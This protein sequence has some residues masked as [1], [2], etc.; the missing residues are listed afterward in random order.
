MLLKLLKRIKDILK[1]KDIKTVSE[2][3][4][5][6]RNKVLKRIEDVNLLFNEMKLCI[7]FERFSEL[8]DDFDDHTL[9]LFI[10][11]KTSKLD[12]CLTGNIDIVEKFFKNIS[13]EEIN[14][15]TSFSETLI[16]ELIYYLSLE[17]NL[18][19]Y[20]KKRKV[21]GYLIKRGANINEGGYM[22]SSPLLIAYK[23][24]S[25]QTVKFLVE[26]GANV[27]QVVGSFKNNIGTEVIDRRDYDLLNYLMSKGLDVEIKV[28][29]YDSLIDYYE[30]RKIKDKFER[31]IGLNILKGKNL[32]AKRN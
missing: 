6:E 23:Y 17:E 29:G 15:K 1:I 8:Y 25:I 4:Y 26:R 27:N 16:S 21:V 32:K 7:T 9:N 20:E 18:K 30:K 10:K 31:K 3:D 5:Y 2:E 24:N 22:D 12:I 28:F 11:Y 13:V 19:E 14:K